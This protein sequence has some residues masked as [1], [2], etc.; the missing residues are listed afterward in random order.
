MVDISDMFILLFNLC[1]FF[2]CVRAQFEYFLY[3]CR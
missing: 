3:I 1:A 2:L